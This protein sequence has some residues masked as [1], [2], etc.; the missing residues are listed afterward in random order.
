MSKI[1]LVAVLSSTVITPGASFR[2]EEVAFADLDLAG[3][4]SFCGHPDTAALLAA[5]GVEPQPR[6]SNFAGLAVGQSFLAVPLKIPAREGGWTV[7]SAVAELGA[8]RPLLVT[9]IA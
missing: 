7:D 6:G 5:F 4:P 8:L 9:R 3:V 1:R 2:C